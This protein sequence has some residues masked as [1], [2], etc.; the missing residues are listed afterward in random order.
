MPELGNYDDK[1]WVK[2]IKINLDFLLLLKY[3]I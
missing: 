2:N 3:K 1:L